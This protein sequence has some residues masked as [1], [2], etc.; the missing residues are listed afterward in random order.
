MKVSKLA[1]LGEDT[2]VISSILCYTLPLRSKYSPQHFAL[3]HTDA[4]LFPHN[5]SN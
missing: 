3:K 4:L 2:H 5:V 1:I